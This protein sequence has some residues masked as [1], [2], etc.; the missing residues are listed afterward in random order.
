MTRNMALS[1][2]V[3]VNLVLLTALCL[4]TY[5]LPAAQAQ[6]TGLAGNYMMVTGEIQNEY[7]A[8]YL[9]DLRER[10]IHAFYWDKGRK[11]LVYSDMRSLERD[12]RNRD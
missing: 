8:L 9:V 4:S 5:S 7:D 2:L 11:Q 12:F 1:L 3:C 10:T 6:G